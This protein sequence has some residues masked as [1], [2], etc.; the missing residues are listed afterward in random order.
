MGLNDGFRWNTDGSRCGTRDQEG[1]TI[2][3]T[4]FLG[5]GKGHESSPERGP[6]G[7]SAFAPRA[8]R[9]FPQGA[10]CPEEISPGPGCKILGRCKIGPGRNEPT[11]PGASTSLALDEAAATE[12][13]LRCN[14]QHPPTPNNSPSRLSSPR[15]W[16]GRMACR[17]RIPVRWCPTARTTGACS[18]FARPPGRRGATPRSSTRTRAAATARS[19]STATMPTPTLAGFSVRRSRRRTGACSD[20]TPATH[21][22]CGRWP[23]LPRPGEDAVEDQIDR[24]GSRTRTTPPVPGRW[25]PFWCAS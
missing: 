3:V 19:R 12:G 18:A 2:R 5:H 20:R 11:Q 16:C 1:C 23:Q 13:G 24:S 15:P 9:K 14:T 10:V 22:R 7:A 6:G 17:S 21:T 25:C 8:S 4:T